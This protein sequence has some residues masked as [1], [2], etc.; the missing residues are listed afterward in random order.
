VTSRDT[1]GQSKGIDLLVNDVHHTVADQDI[2]S[3]NLGRVNVDS[4]VVHGEGD[5]LA[6][7]GL[8][9]RSILDRGAIGDSAFDDMV[10]QDGRQLLLSQIGN[11]VANGV[12][13]AVVGDEDG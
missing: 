7:H 8:D 13:G 12:E 3:H 11:Q 5:L 2:G 4:A 9:G 6:V 10:T 1:R